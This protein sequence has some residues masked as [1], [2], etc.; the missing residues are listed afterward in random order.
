MN[1]STFVDLSHLV[2]DGQL[3][4]TA[5]EGD[6]TWRVFSFWEQYTNQRANSPGTFATDFI[7]N[8]SWT[9][10]HFSATGAKVVTDF[11]DTYILNDTEL[12]DLVRAVGNYGMSWLLEILLLLT[13]W[14]PGKTA[15]KYLPLCTGLLASSTNFSKIMAT[16]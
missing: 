3:N 11:W 6:S 12:A 14:Q 10:D 15:W 1:E 4:W 5:P 9:V 13:L 2:V 16:V 7:G 8:G